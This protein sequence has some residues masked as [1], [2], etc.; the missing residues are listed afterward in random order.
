M[1]NY[2]LVISVYNTNDKTSDIKSQIIKFQILIVYDEK[3]YYM[4]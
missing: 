3:Y 1:D 4:E 2:F